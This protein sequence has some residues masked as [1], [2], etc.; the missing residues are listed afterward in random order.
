M[1]FASH[2]ARLDS[3]SATDSRELDRVCEEVATALYEGGGEPPFTVESADFAADAHLIC[4][5]RYWR[6][7]FLE[8]PD[9]RTA[10]DC[11]RWL[12][13]HVT[14]EH[15]TEVLEKWS[16]GYAFITKDTVESTAELSRAV[17]EIVGQENSSGDVAYFAT[18]YHAGK[19]RSNFWFD[20]LHQFLDSSLLTLA[21]GV[22]RRS[23]LFTALRSFA[24]FG[25]RAITAEHA[26]GLL[27]QA[28]NSPERT[29]H[30]VDICL[31]GINVA[32]PFEGHG[33]LLRD[34]AA[35]AVRDHPFDHI[36]HFR[37]AA[38][39]HLVRDEDAALVSITT[40]LRHLPALGSRGSHKL[41]QEQYL[42]KRDAI[43]EGGRRALLDAEHEQRLRAQ[44]ARHQQRY[45]QLEAELHR[46]GDEQA[47]AHREGQEA[48]RAN[49]VRSVEL[50]AVFTSAIAFAVGSLQVSLTGSFTLRDRL[51]LIGAWGVAHVVFALLVVGG[52]WLI[53][54]PRPSRDGS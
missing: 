10:A 50:V 12:N 21:A 18:L 52:T 37:L 9:I 29:R 34:R 28:W 48:A 40:A 3:I 8:R 15:R 20:E 25:S 45:E 36:F 22:H 38:G 49:H 16:L 17:E 7:R 26:T 39:Q 5:D 24:A 14:R 51:F 33:E 41:L 23:A 11:S 54:R 19:L 42:A 1:D 6:L 27:D 46:R 32:A 47:K 31:N 44:E 13:V 43:L 53:T 2:T 30:V 35:E 4:A